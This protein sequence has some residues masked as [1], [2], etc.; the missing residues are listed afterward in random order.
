MSRLMPRVS[1][2]VVA[3][4]YWQLI[5][6]L[7][8]TLKVIGYLIVLFLGVGIVS[9]A[10]GVVFSE[11]QPIATVL[12]GVS[13]LIISIIGFFCLPVG[14]LIL[15]SN[16]NINLLGNVRQKLFFIALIFSL[17]MLTAY[18][19]FVG[20]SERS[21]SPVVFIL[22]CLLFCP[23]YFLLTIF[24]ANKD[25]GLSIF[26]PLFVLVATQSAFNYVSHFSPVVLV[27]GDL[28]GWLLFYR[29]WARFVSSW[30]NTKSV[31]LQ[32]ERFQMTESLLEK[33]LIFRAGKIR[34][35]MGTFLLGHSDHISSFLKRISVMF[36]FCLSCALFAQGGFNVASFDDEKLRIA[37]FV[38][39]AYS[40]ILMS[41]D[42]YS[43]KMM[44]NLKRAWLIFPG[45]REGLFFYIESF[46]WRGLALLAVLNFTML[47][48]FLLF[49]QSL[50]YLAYVMAG[51]VVMSL[52]VTLDFYW[53]IYC[54]R[55]GQEV[56]HINFRKAIVSAFLVMLGCV[57]LVGK[58]SNF[59]MLE[60]K[61]AIALLVVLSAVGLLKLARKFCMK[62]FTLA[63][64]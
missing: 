4:Q 47:A 59:N 34:T 61:D 64:I 14:M 9:V 35:P 11:F 10:L 25:V 54:Y 29:W 17:V 49:T 37:I 3:N 58:Y 33:L 52:I 44:L 30:G 42:F 62:R 63:D 40:F 55:K 24:A 43:K 20:V 53:D 16:K 50:Q 51:I 39:C 12:A 18:S 45:N 26:A 60:I 2:G 7:L 32:T 48:L 31:F 22:S 56:G 19:F 13:F 28:V 5:N 1:I 21:I 6:A 23:I 8:F 41:M 38:S 15:I 36:L 46:F 57:Y 27:L